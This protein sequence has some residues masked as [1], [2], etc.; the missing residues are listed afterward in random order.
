MK[1]I[2]FLLLLSTLLFADDDYN[3]KHHH[4]YNKDLT[5][6]NLT[7]VQKKSIKALLKEYRKDLKVYRE[8]KEDILEEKEDIFEKEEFDREKF[9]QINIKL[10]N[11]ASKI[12]TKLLENIHK[13]LS[14][15][16]RELFIKYIDEWEIE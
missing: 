13:I 2:L 3:E 16:Q 7:N 8:Y 6:L 12:E 5:Y 15:E 1:F 9:I 10:A 4:Y 11:E 14:K